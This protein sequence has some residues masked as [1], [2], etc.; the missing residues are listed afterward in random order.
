MQKN[1]CQASA[2]KQ[3]RTAVFWFIMQKVA[4]IS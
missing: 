1:C 3:M 4:V 2:T